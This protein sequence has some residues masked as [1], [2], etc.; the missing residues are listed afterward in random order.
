MNPAQSKTTH[1][2]KIITNT[3]MTSPNSDA[4]H[5]PMIN[6]ILTFLRKFTRPPAATLFTL[7][8][9]RTMRL[10]RPHG[11]PRSK[12]LRALQAKNY[13]AVSSQTDHH[14]SPSSRYRLKT[15]VIAGLPFAA[16]ASTD[17]SNNGL[18]RKP[19]S[20]VYTAIS[21]IPLARSANSL[22]SKGLPFVHGINAYPT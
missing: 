22:T 14:F 21:V 19:S 7:V 11:D 10:A 5:L 15:S 4:T 9:I 1:R 16:I 17:G 20:D 18:A 13:L 12:T 6:F 8:L 3:A 2:K